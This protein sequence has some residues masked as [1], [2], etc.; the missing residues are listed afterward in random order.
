MQLKSKDIFKNITD[1][2]ACDF[3]L[4]WTVA[5]INKKREPY[6]IMLS[7]LVLLAFNTSSTHSESKKKLHLLVTRM[8]VLHDEMWDEHGERKLDD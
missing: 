6:D 5:V 1:R 3:L 2:E 8:I 4:R 7:L